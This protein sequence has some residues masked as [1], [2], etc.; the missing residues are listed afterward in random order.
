[1]RYSY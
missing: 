1:M